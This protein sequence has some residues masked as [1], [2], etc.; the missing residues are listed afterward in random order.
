MESLR[1]SAGSSVAGG[2]VVQYVTQRPSAPMAQ[3][4]KFRVNAPGSVAGGRDDDGVEEVEEGGVVGR[5]LRR[6]LLWWLANT[7]GFRV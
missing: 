5:V 1:S 2:G 7:L 4:R 3:P 6:Y